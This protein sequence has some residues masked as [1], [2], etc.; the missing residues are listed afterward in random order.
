VQVG[1]IVEGLIDLREFGKINE[2]P[3]FR[4]FLERRIE[5]LAYE[6]PRCVREKSRHGRVQDGSRF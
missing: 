4:A 5:T 6:S 2:Q 3:T 1:S